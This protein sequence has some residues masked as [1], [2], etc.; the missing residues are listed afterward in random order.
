MNKFAAV[1]WSLMIP[2]CLASRAS[3]E[4]QPSPVAVR[5]ALE[6]LLPG[7][8][9][10]KEVKTNGQRASVNAASQNQQQVSDFMRRVVASSV[11]HGVD[12]VTMEKSG[13]GSTTFTLSMEVHCPRPG[14]HVTNNP[15][16][17]SVPAQPTVYKCT[18]GGATSYQSTPCAAASRR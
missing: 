9:I 3:A 17:A 18:V 4:E 8:V 14:E 13:S 16:D 7:G 11:F 15:C 2:L 12:L 5:H 6:S 10:L 1:G